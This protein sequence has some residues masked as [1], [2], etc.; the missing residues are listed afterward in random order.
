MLADLA[1]DDRICLFDIIR[2]E[3]LS[4]A[5]SEP[6]Y[7]M[8]EDRLA[9][10]P[11]LEMPR[12]FWN[13]VARTRFHLA[14]KGFQASIPDVSIGVIARYYGCALLTLDRPLIQVAK[15]LSLKLYRPR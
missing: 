15:L 8:L 1:E 10:L 2:I 9:G 13:Q 5:R 14:R 7:R 3:L 4:G 12:G 6:E 11:W